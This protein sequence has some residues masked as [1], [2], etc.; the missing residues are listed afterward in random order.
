[1]IDAIV[2]FHRESDI[3]NL[4]S[5]QMGSFRDFIFVLVH[6][7][8]FRTCEGE[9][10]KLLASGS[11]VRVICGEFGA[12]GLARNA[13][14]A[15]SANEWIVFLDGDDTPNLESIMKISREASQRD[16]NVYMGSFREVDPLNN[17]DKIREIPIRNIS[18]YI[19]KNPG[20]WRFG[21]KRNLLDE[22]TF[23]S[24]RWGEDQLFLL[25]IL[26][27]PGICIHIQNECVYEYKI[28]RGNRLTNK[29]DLV[30][31]LLQVLAIE[32]SQFSKVRKRDVN[33]LYDLLTTKQILTIIYRLRSRSPKGVI[34]K[35]FFF[36]L[37]L[38]RLGR[39]F[40]FV[41][42]IFCIKF[43]RAYRKNSYQ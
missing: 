12:P 16:C 19:A 13:G 6:D 34:A 1:M 9:C 38:R 28:Y 15:I 33:E 30:T 32:F 35:A 20:L 11:N 21:F 40:I 10:Q 29:T 7:S 8:S 43:T 5:W 14:M 18:Q 25:N 27:Q 3:E 24:H 26:S 31:D 37:S 36:P 2:P 42:S 4:F 22:V 39:K 17:V 41:G 23:T